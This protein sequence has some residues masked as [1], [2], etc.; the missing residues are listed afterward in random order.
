VFPKS[1]KGINSFDFIFE[2]FNS[3]R[4]WF[5]VPY[6][7][8]KVTVSDYIMGNCSR[9][10]RTWLRDNMYDTA[11]SI[12][13]DTSYA[14]ETTPPIRHITTLQLQISLRIVAE[15]KIRSFGKFHRKKSIRCIERSP[16]A[17]A[18]DLRGFLI[19]SMPE[20]CG[21]SANPWCYTSILYM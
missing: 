11:S 16:I 18:C 13:P 8:S 2:I 19:K 1:K 12:D 6:H 21:V 14:I 20:D 4:K 17:V 3:G 5:F 15:S 7:S 10:W 9:S